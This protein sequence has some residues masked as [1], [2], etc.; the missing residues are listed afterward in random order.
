[1]I[2]KI[3]EKVL[4]MFEEDEPLEEKEFIAVPDDKKKKRRRKYIS[5]AIAFNRT[6]ETINGWLV[7]EM[8]STTDYKYKVQC[9]RCKRNFVRCI[10]QVIH[11][12]A[13]ACYICSKKSN[14]LK[15]QRL[16]DEERS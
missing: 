14:K 3:R 2:D 7:K 1:M 10:Y 8:T 16:F 6:G 15:M 9:L 4:L 13:V 12:R 5:G 11:G